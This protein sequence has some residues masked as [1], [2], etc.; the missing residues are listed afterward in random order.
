MSS[1]ALIIE[2]DRDTAL[3]FNHILEFIGFSTEIVCNSEG[4]F[5][6][7]V[8]TTPDVVLLDI[9]LGQSGTGIKILE[10][11]KGEERL[12]NCRVIVI[13]GYPDRAEEIED[14]ADV[15]FIKPI[16]AS[17]LSKMVLRMVPKQVGRNFLYSASY[18]PVTGLM[19]FFR[20]KEQ[21]THAINRSKRKKELFFALILIQ[22]KGYI[23][24][25][26]EIGDRFTN[27]FLVD[28]VGR[29]KD[30]IREVD[31]FSRLSEDN[32]AILLE[33]IKE[34]GNA[35]T[36]AKRIQASLD[37]PFRIQDREYRINCQIQVKQKDLI[38]DFDA[39]IEE[40]S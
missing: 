36:V 40:F 34:S 3:L 16:S 33:D 27:M 30:Q 35:F 31:A 2:D 6:H 38:H 4:A 20:F 21:M 23:K 19:N 15:V 10:Y 24:L 14:Q 1:F 25:K 32:F 39:F 29:T 5:T 7:L 18:D 26:K 8:Q 22:I 13:T 12:S 11:I 9:M 17:Q 28:F 37:K